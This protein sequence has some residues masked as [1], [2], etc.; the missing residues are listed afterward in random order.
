MIVAEKK[1]NPDVGGVRGTPIPRLLSTSPAL[2][3][4]EH[5]AR[6]GIQQRSLQHLIDEGILCCAA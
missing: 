5:E 3:L 6:Y 4:P 2:T 1:H